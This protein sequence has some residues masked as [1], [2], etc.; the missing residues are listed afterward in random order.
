MSNLD[1]DFQVAV[2]NSP[3]VRV[4]VPNSFMEKKTANYG[5][6]TMDLFTKSGQAISQKCEYTI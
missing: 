4:T 6:Q 2:M 1:I 3:M 5:D